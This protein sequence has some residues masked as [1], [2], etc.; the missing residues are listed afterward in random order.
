LPAATTWR[1]Q[2]PSPA[3]KV[4]PGSNQPVRV[5]IEAMDRRTMARFSLAAFQVR[6]LGTVGGCLG[7]LVGAFAGSVVAAGLTHN[8]FMTFPGV[9]IGALVGAAVGVFISLRVMAR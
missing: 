2:D 7:M 3:G 8:A 4:E 5:Q 1:A 9:M 6:C